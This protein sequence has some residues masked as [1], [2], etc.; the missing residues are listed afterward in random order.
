MN[1]FQ[2]STCVPEGKTARSRADQAERLLAAMHS[3]FSHDLPNQLV[4]IQGLANLLELEEKQSLSPQAQEFM[5]RLAGAAKRASG[6]VQFLKQMARLH[7]VQEPLERIQLAPLFREIRAELTQL[8][9]GRTFVFD[10]QWHA[11]A[12]RAGGRA[13]HQAMLEVVRHGIEACADSM[14]CL[15]LRSQ[16]LGA[17]VELDLE[18]IAGG[19]ADVPRPPARMDKPSLENCLELRLARAALA[20]WGGMLELP[21]GPNFLVRMLMPSA[22]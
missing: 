22:D 17:D 15:C 13:L 9:P 14:P 2:E 7:R 1:A 20:S 4:I 5:T 18:V 8:F 10:T 16:H 11:P 6:M 19:G 3:V 21:P 12:V